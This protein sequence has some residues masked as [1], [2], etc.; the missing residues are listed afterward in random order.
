MKPIK[1][2]LEYILF[3][4]RKIDK[5]ALA[6]RLH[7]KTILITGASFGI[8][9]ALCYQLADIDCQLIL[10]ARTAEKLEAIKQQL[11]TKKA[12]IK[13]FSVNLSDDK[14]LSEFITE[15]SQ[16]TID[17]FVNNAGKSICRPIMQSLDRYHDFQR[18]MQLNYV[19]PVKLC[20][21]LIP[22]LQKNKGQIINVSAI[23]VL[24]APT[25][26]WA[27]YQASKTAF[28]Q[29]LGCAKSELAIN[30]IVVSSLYLP[31]VRTRM[32]APTRA[33][34]HVPVMEVEQAATRISKLLLNRKAYSKPWWSIFGQLGSVFLLRLWLKI[35][36]YYLRKKND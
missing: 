9:E 13:L 18:T 25:P 12:T 27:A 10:V 23:N 24:L 29:W 1:R 30:E 21:A 31:L 17:I 20:L 2:Y 28:D 7:H 32:I 3:P 14:Q 34:Q 33:Y 8:G 15:L 19:A 36:E 4:H 11:A 5:E 35:T 6:K 22:Q 26:Y 16:F